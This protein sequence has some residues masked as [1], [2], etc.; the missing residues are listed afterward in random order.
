MATITIHLNE[1]ERIAL[2]ELC[3]NELR[4]P[5]QQVL[6]IVRYYLIEHGYLKLNNNL[7]E[8]EDQ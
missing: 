4:D 3:E 1:Q 5:R 2:V 8:E 6:W 7:E